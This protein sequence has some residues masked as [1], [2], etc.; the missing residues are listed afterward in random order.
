MRITPILCVLAFGCGM[1]FAQ[2]SGG[3]A[4]AIPAGGDKCADQAAIN[5]AKQIV[6]AWK[7]GYNGGNA[8]GV[9]A[10]YSEDAFYLTQHFASGIVHGRAGIQAYV[11][12]GV[13]A[14]Y[15]IDS[16]QIVSVGCS[17]DLMY[18]VARYEANNAGEKV[19]GV[20]LV[21]VRRSG[22]DWR[23]VAHEAAVPDPGTAIQRLD[24]PSS[25]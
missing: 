11:Q 9:A 19:F 2:G 5:A 20:N 3:R 13:D 23:I 8:A 15:R 7:S 6:D 10:L 17:G 21:V 1:V 25:R 18:T 22:S 14:G 24:I 4:L 16:L 12:R